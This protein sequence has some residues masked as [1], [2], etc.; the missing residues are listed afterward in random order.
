MNDAD[1]A[2]ALLRV[3]VDEPPSSVGP[4]MRDWDQWRWYAQLQRVVPELVELVAVRGELD[5]AQERQLRSMQGDAMTWAVRLEYH[6][7]SV[8]DLL[9]KRG[10]DYAVLKG[11]ATAHLDY[12]VPEWRQI[13]DIDLLVSPASFAAAI[14]LIERDGWLQ[15]YAL[16]K[17]HR[18]FTHAVTFIKDNIELDLHQHIAHRAIGL[19]VPTD[20][21]L[22]K[23]R[24]YRV[25]G[26]Q[27]WA[28]S[29][30]DRLIHAALHAHL[31]RGETKR[32]SS[33]ADV[34]VM[35][36]RRRSEAAAV[37]ERSSSWSIGNL[38]NTGVR[39]AFAAADLTVPDAWQDAFRQQPP[40]RWTERVHLAEPVR[41]WATEL[42]YLA[43]LPTWSDRSRY[44]G[45]HLAGVDGAGGIGRRVAYLR[46]KITGGHAP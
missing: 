4:T 1:L 23:H 42:A 8:V 36:T 38:V 10:I 6:L 3:A 12:P 2:A 27:L 18:R 35:A 43:R 13:G 11:L 19:M 44:V 5:R 34:L 25:A 30:V 32:L 16:P 9:D 40:P 14:E 39:A 41:P 45:G 24:P 31:S 17:G 15:G 29:D 22:A 46:R 33:A 21:L 7:L 26:R 28:L 20:E 37:A